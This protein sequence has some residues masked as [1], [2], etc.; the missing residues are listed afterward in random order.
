MGGGNSGHPISLN[1]LVEIP[2]STVYSIE[3]ELIETEMYIAESW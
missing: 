2:S 1:S 3:V